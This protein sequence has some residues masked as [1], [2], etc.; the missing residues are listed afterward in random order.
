MTR[1]VE[2]FLVGVESTDP[3]TFIGIPVLLLGVALIA[4]YIPAR[5]AAGVA[6]V[7]ALSDE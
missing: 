2:S 6:P 7:V 1:V 3:V 5:R 4:T